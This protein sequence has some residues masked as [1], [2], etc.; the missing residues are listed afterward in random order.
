VIFVLFLVPLGI[1]FLVL[2]YLNR[3]PRPIFVSGTLDFIGILF[4][5]SGFLLFGGPAVLSSLYEKWRMLWLLG[6]VG[7]AG[8]SLA[9]HWSFWVT[10]SA[11]YFL[12]VVGGCAFAFRRYRHLTSIYNVEPALAEQ[13]LEEICEQFGLAH[14]RS[15]NVFVFGLGLDR[16]GPA[17]PTAEGIQAPHAL[18]YLAQKTPGARKDRPAESAEVLVGQSAVLEVESFRALR[19][20]TLRW[21]PPDSPLRPVLEAELERRLGVLGAPEHDTGALLA[22]I[23]YALLGLA[24]LVGIF[25]LLRSILMR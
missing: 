7:G 1:Y 10:L 25:L 23:G 8:D 4:A 13:V 19:H 20:V 5:V 15:G 9:E 18:P 24:L 22:V 17:G 16:P 3:Q 11:V 6:E 14:I 2:A 21:D 12:L